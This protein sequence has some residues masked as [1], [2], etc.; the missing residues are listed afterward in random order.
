MK[1]QIWI[2][3][4]L[5]FLDESFQGTCFSHVFSKACQYAIT[6]EKVCRNFR[7]VSIKPTQLNLYKHTTWAKRF[8]E[9]KDEWNKACS[10]SKLHLRKSNILVKTR[11]VN[12]ELYFTT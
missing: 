9:G 4:Q 10:N 2:L 7:F 5:F 8:G 12:F 3:Q 11:K 1:G 6:N